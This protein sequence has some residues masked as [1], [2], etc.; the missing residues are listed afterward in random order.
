MF[1]HCSSQH[2]SRSA[3][4]SFSFSSVSGF[5]NLFRTLSAVLMLGALLS[6]GLMPKALAQGSKRASTYDRVEEKDK[7]RPDLRDGWMMR[8][9]ST[10]PGSIGRRTASAS[11]PAET[12]NASGDQEFESSYTR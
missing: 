7:D 5:S 2:S 11:P 8:G 1:K 3:S 9:R 4:P 12:R 10:P 6:N